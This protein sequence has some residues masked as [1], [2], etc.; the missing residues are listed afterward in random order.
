MNILITGAAGHIGSA[1]IRKIRVPKIN[2][3][4][5]VDNLSTQ[6]Y[7]SLFDLPKSNNFRFYEMDILSPEIGQI[8]KNSRLVVHLAALTDAET[9]FYK[10]RILDRTNKQGL[11]HVA[12]LCARYHSFLVFPSTTSVYGQQTGIVDENCSKSDLKPQSPYATSKLYG[13][14]ILGEFGKTKKLSYVILRLGTIVGWSLGMRFHTAVNKFIWQAITNQELTVWQTARYQKRPYLSLDDCIAAFNYILS[15]ELFSQNI[16][17]IVTDNLTVND[18]I[19]TIRLYIPRLKC[20]LVKSPIMNQL[21][22]QVSG[23]KFIRQGFTYR[24]DIQTNIMETI[25]KL[26]QIYYYR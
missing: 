13:E 6:R 17:N 16:Y 4:F 3:I 1:F 15:K 21:S 5:L 20:K 11:K 19:K 26:K 8:I 24:S 23:Q 7:A 2:K 22:Y 18:I 25:N 10:P 12:E 9:S 14:N